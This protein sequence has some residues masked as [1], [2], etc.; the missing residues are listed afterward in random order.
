[1][2]EPE[3]PARG[4]Q[5]AQGLKKTVPVAVLKS[6]AGRRDELLAEIELTYKRRYPAFL[7]VAVAIN[8]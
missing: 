7:R 1:M 5:D 3:L 8:R 4:L 6:V 2:V